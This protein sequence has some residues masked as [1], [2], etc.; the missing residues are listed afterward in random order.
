NQP[1]YISLLYL[2]TFCVRDAAAVVR[3]G[4]MPRKKNPKAS[5]EV[6]EDRAASEQ[7]TPSDQVS[8]NEQATPS[9]QATPNEQIATS[10][11]ASTVWVHRAHCPEGKKLQI[12]GAEGFTKIKLKRTVHEIWDEAKGADGPDIAKGATSISKETLTSMPLFN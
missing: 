9:E 8:A 4:K 6:R 5:E 10:E 2:S 7:A 11:S 3:K 1:E 12:P